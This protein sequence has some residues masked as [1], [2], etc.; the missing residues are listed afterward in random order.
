MTNKNLRSRYYVGQHK[1]YASRPT[2]NSHYPSCSV[3][4]TRNDKAANHFKR[5][6]QIN[7][8]NYLY[9]FCDKNLKL[10]GLS[11]ARAESLKKSL[12]YSDTL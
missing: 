7:K 1:S 4:K 9:E 8:A 10:S 6:F 2:L 12:S 3:C 5:L 11:E